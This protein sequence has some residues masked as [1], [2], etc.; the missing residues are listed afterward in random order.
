VHREEERISILIKRDHQ[1][2]PQFQNSPSYS[3]ADID[4]AQQPDSEFD[5]HNPMGACSP[6]GGLLRTG[7]RRGGYSHNDV[8]ITEG[9]DRALMAL[10][11]LAEA[12]AAPFFDVLFC[13]GCISGPKMLNDLRTVRAQ[14]NWW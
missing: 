11:E 5:G 10:H 7:W 9:K 13:E 12:Q 1:Q 6:S 14:G 8:V 4:I 3:T 2:R